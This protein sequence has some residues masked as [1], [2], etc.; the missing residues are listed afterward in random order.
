M[1]KFAE[2]DEWIK[3]KGESLLHSS[4]DYDNLNSGIS[5][6]TLKEFERAYLQAKPKLLFAKS[7]LVDEETFTVDFVDS[8]SMIEE[9]KDEINKR[10][11]FH[12]KNLQEINFTNPYMLHVYFIHEGIIVSY[13]VFNEDY[14]DMN[15]SE[16]T[17]EKIQSEVLEI[18]D[19]EK[20][21]TIKLKLVEEAEEK[22][23]EITDFILLDEEFHSS[24][25]GALRMKY[26]NKLFVAHPEFKAKISVAG[27]R[28]SSTYSDYVWKLYKDSKKLK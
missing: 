26:M 19:E 16:E 27:Y 28:K 9:I 23:K 14:A 7:L 11:C 5:L 18:Y 6:L 12:N 22:L 24:T 8:Q 3:N 13:S 25:N 4:I 1:N 21:K 10:I 20:L 15:S 17:Y 2:L